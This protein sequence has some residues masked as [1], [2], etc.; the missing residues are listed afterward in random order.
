MKSWLPLL[1]L[2]CLAV[3]SADAREFRRL[4][5][6]ARPDALPSGAQRPETIRPLSRDVVEQAVRD[7]A[8]AWNSGQLSDLLASDMAGGSRLQDTLAEVMPRDARLTVLAVQGISTLDQYLQGKT[9][10]STVRAVVRT[11]VEFNDPRVGYKR[12]EG[13]NEWYFRVEE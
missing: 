3:Q 11:Q 7:V 12:L 8:A 13:L 10:I 2:A 9:R 1:F 4:T 5:T 6:I